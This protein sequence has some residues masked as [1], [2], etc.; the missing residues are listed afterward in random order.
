MTRKNRSTHV[1]DAGG[2]LPQPVASGPWQPWLE[3]AGSLTARIVARCPPTA[4]FSVRVLAHGNGLPHGDECRLIGVAAHRLAHRRDVLLMSGGTSLVY[5]HTVAPRDSLRRA[6]Q[7]MDR[8]GSRALGSM[9]FADPRVNR[10]TLS[11]RRLDHRHPLYQEAIG[12]CPAG[13]PAPAV[14]WGRRAVF[15]LS[16]QPLLVTEV[17][18]PSIL[19]LHP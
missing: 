11:F 6:W 9:L 3:E 1:P 8:V 19:S 13:V 18:L 15:A 4:P 17:F 2:W 10:G 12:W 14:L 5:A 16:G 7:L